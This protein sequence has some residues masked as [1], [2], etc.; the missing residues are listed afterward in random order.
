MA[1]LGVIR[2]KPKGFFDP[3]ARGREDFDQQHNLP[4]T[5]V[6][7]AQGGQVASKDDKIAP[8]VFRQR[9]ITPRHAGNHRQMFR[10]NERHGRFSS[11]PIITVEPS[12]AYA[13][14][15]HTFDARPLGCA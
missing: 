3:A 5:L 10:S 8:Q 7:L 11:G 14:R 1:A 9:A 12:S 2:A 4:D 13:N 6:H 15:R